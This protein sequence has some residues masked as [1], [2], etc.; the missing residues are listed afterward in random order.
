MSEPHDLR[1]LVGEDVTAEELERLRTVDTLIRSTPPPPPEV[2]ASLTRAVLDRRVVHLPNR[3]RAV[4][5]A[6]L[7]AAL[8]ALSFAAGRW[9]D[10]NGF[11][12]R[13]AVVMQATTDAPNAAAVI[14]LAER[15]ASGNWTLELEA[16]GLPKLPKGDSYVL[17]LAK[18][19]QYAATCGYFQLRSGA[20]TVQMNG[21]YR[22]KDFDTWVI[23]AHSRTNPDAPA[24]WLLKAPVRA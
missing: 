8:A 15:D 11:D 22:L 4:L 9:T 3:R 12:A 6:T 2:P 13:A 10:D 23:T 19:G 17:W 16:S 1:D 5:A 24:P 21:A 14:R 20:A 7:A 18:D